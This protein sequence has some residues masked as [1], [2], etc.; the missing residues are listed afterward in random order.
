M[1]CHHDSIFCCFALTV[2]LLLLL[3][4]W[5]LVFSNFAPFGRCLAICSVPTPDFPRR[6]HMLKTTCQLYANIATRR[7]D[8]CWFEVEPSSS[9]PTVHC[10]SCFFIFKPDWFNPAQRSH[11]ALVIW[12]FTCHD[13]TLEPTAIKH[14]YFCTRLVFTYSSFQSHLK[15]MFPFWYFGCFHQERHPHD[16]T[17]GCF[18][19]WKEALKSIQKDTFP[20][21]LRGNPDKPTTRHS[22]HSLHIW[23]CFI[24]TTL[25]SA[26]TAFRLLSYSSSFLLWPLFGCCSLGKFLYC[27]LQTCAALRL[28]SSTCTNPPNP[29][30]GPFFPTTAHALAW[31]NFPYNNGRSVVRLPELHVSTSCTLKHR[32]GRHY[33][34]F[35][36]DSWFLVDL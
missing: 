1:I 3:S 28:S 25:S 8:S 23:C 31:K 11:F 29:S 32:M 34:G 2:V 14:A 17:C 4:L 27:Q 13:L 9:C 20:R 21:L 5:F 19:R 7:L 10:C 6:W 35:V 18:S 22:L 12:T 26:L 15:F 36:F 30:T 33:R 16:N 24:A